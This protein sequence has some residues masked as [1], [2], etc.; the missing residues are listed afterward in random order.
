MITTNEILNPGHYR[1][2]RVYTTEL[3]RHFERKGFDLIG[4]VGDDN[5]SKPTQY[6]LYGDIR[7]ITGREK[8]FIELFGKLKKKKEHFYGQTPQN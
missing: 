7:K 2:F 5:V 6:T 4:T 1:V 8:P 3:V